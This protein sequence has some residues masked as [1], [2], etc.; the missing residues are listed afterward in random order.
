MFGHVLSSMRAEVMF[1]ARWRESMSRNLY[2]DQPL[3]TS[4]CCLFLRSLI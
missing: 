4:D 1:R 3:R 2:L